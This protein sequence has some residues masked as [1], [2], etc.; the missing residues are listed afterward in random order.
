ML[1]VG[2][3]LACG[4]KPREAEPLPSEPLPARPTAELVVEHAGC[5]VSTRTPA[6]CTLQGRERE[7]RLWID[8][9]E[10]P[11]V[12]L[13]GVARAEPPVR[14]GNELE[15][16]RARVAIP[17]GAR[18]LSVRTATASWRMELLDAPPTP[19]LDAIEKEMPEL[20]D[21]TRTAAFERLLPR[22]ERAI[23]ETSG[24]ESV[25]L[26]R[27]ST[28]VYWDLGR[29]DEAIAASR[30]TIDAALEGGFAAIAIDVAQN[31]SSFVSDPADA[32]WLL[33]LQTLYVPTVGD[34]Q[35]TTVWHYARGYQAHQAGELGRALAELEKSEQLARR[36]G[37]DEEELTAIA[38]KASLLALLGREQELG[39]TTS[40]IL[41]LATQRETGEACND[42]QNLANTGLSLVQA[43]ST[44]QAAGDDS[45]R[46]LERALAYYA[47]GG[48]CAIATNSAWALSLAYTRIF[49]AMDALSH[50]DFAG[51]AN[52][53]KPFE[54]VEL[55]SDL[56][57]MLRYLRAE[58]AF[59]DGRARDALAEV[60]TVAPDPSDTLLTWHSTM[61]RADILSQ[62]GEREQALAGYL[63]AEAV[64]DRAVQNVAM[65]QGREGLGSGMHRGAARAIALLLDAG[66]VARA[67]RVARRSRSR[68]LRPAGRAANV[69]RLSPDKRRSYNFEVARYREL[70]DMIA[71]ELIAADRLPR[72]ERLSMFRRHS[73]LRTEMH[74]ALVR[75]ESLLSAEPTETEALELPAPGQVW[76][77]YHPG[78]RGWFGFAITADETIA[79]DLGPA[80]PTNDPLALSSWLLAPFDD[81]LSQTREVH[82]LAMGALLAID[83]ADLP[84]AEGPLISERAVA[85]GLDVS[86]R[87]T[88]PKEK[89]ALVVGDPD[90]DDVGSAGRLLRARQEAL[91]AGAGLERAGFAVEVLIG[92]DAI[93]SR[94]LP[95]LSE[96]DWF[97][98]AGHGVSD[99]LGGWDSALE[100]A[101]ETRLTVR[102][103]LAQPSVP[104]AV[105]LSACQ[106]AKVDARTASGGMH[107]ASAFLLAGASFVIAAQDDVADETA[108]RLAASLYSGSAKL[109]E[110]SGPELLRAALLEQGSA[111]AGRRSSFRVW[112]P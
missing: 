24:L 95:A 22:L 109:A 72:D 92:P 47:P 28:L 96:V 18:E 83:F 64:L 2:V 94:V 89:R 66:D 78:E 63:E 55:S 90:G 60:A 6:T 34:G 93:R 30:R 19:V 8:A 32:A 98:H 76:L 112:V 21:P 104:R 43:A 62:I 41:E 69:A 27:M 67:A 20:S 53:L 33:E 87:S 31:L 111:A 29:M 4:S 42:A 16:W 57:G 100:L 12:E 86:R 5:T 59:H 99:G 1:T 88:E 82:V 36:L 91:D 38:L 54:G 3:M 68:A 37:M 74:A 105:I 40:R 13:D 70:S 65:D 26:R 52:R 85:Y 77:V 110:T 80:P 7:L 48:G 101:G 44:T 9:I 15:G 75:A 35:L 51:L 107:L 79:N 81:V 103:V 61:L 39:R 73:D 102:D 46:I 17:A 71:G 23:E 58:L 10:E 14:V 84:R 25:L 97:H 49:Y 50:R 45:T 108:S 56:V 11:V 106:T